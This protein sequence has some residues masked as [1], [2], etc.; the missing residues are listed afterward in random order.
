MC[1]KIHQTHAENDFQWS[2]WRISFLSSTFSS[3]DMACL[4]TWCCGLFILF[5]GSQQRASCLLHGWSNSEPHSQVF[6]S[7]MYSIFVVLF[8]WDKVSSSLGWPQTHGLAQFLI[9]LPL[10]GEY[11]C[12]PA[13][14]A[15]ENNLKSLLS[16]ARFKLFKIKLSSGHLLVKFYPTALIRLAGLMVSVYHIILMSASSTVISSQC[17]TS[18][19]AAGKEEHESTQEVC[20]SVIRF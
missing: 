10:L 2:T 14:P 1:S 5:C 17:S 13:R 8:V 15:A 6:Y 3:G 12:V 11:G 20:R 9:L 4:S 7:I 19:K 18:D 16:V